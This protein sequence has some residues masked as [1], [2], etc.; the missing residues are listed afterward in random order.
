[1]IQN[2]ISHKLLHAVMSKKSVCGEKNQILQ[3]E[4][5]ARLPRSQLVK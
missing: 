4:V 2:T 1:M 3:S 5:I